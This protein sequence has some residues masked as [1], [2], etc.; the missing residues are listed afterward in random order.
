MNMMLHISF[1]VMLNVSFGIFIFYPLGW[2]FMLVIMLL[3]S[4]ILSKRLSK[5]WFDGKCTLTAFL[6]NIVSGLFGLFLSLK[7]NGGWWMVLWLPWVSRHEVNVSD[8]N[9]LWSLLAYYVAAF[10]L[11][12][13]IELVVNMLCLHKRYGRQSVLKATLVANIVS[14]LVGSIVLYSFSF[15]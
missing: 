5:K 1:P 12:V 8:A 2:L 7:L 4:Y 14:Y 10:V 3:E 6:S 11:S 9:V 13:V 15:S